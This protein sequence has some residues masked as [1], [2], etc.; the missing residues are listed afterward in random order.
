[1]SAYSVQVKAARL[2]RQLLMYRFVAFVQGFIAARVVFDF[3]RGDE[4]PGTTLIVI[5]AVGCCAFWTGWRIRFVQSML[6]DIE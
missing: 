6:R 1:M 3:V 4:R 2:R 5:F